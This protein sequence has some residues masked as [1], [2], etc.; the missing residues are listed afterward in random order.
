MSEWISVKDRLPE[1]QAL[2]MVCNEIGWMQYQKAI[3]YPAQNVFVHYDPQW[4]D[5]LTLDV[6]HW[7]ELPDTPD[8]A[9][10]IKE[11]DEK[12]RKVT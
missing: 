8:I 10:K 1:K 2:V 12:E 7:L 11:R 9:L 3:Y 6:T 5:K 4:Y